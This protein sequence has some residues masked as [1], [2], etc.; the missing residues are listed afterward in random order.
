VFR[1]V[2]EIPADFIRNQVRLQG[3]VNSVG[4]NGTLHIQHIPILELRVPL[5]PRK[6]RGTSCSIRKPYLL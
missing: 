3:R 6:D 1:H 2:D 4:D 5:T